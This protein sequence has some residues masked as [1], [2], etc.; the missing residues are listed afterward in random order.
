MATASPSDALELDGVVAPLPG[1]ALLEVT[2]RHRER[3]LAS[4]LTSD[5]A[6][7]AEGEPQLS[8]L[9]DATGR[10]QAL[11]F[12][13]RRAGAFDLLV[14]EPAA[15]HCAERLRSHVI[16]DDV[17]VRQREVG[18]MRLALGPAAVALAAELD[19]AERIPVA[20]W[21]AL[22]LVTW[23]DARFELEAIDD[24]EIEARRVLGGPP[25]W[26][27]E[28]EPGQLVNET[29]LLGS[30]VSFSKGCYR[31]QET[32]AKV[33]SHR[34]A[35]RAPVLLEVPDGLGDGA[36]LV[37]RTFGVGERARAGRALG[38][39]HHDGTSWLQLSLHRELRVAGRQLECAFDGGT[40]VRGTVR[41]LPLL[42][43]PTLEE[44]AERLTTAA[45]AAFA[46]D[47]PDRAL[48]LLD[49]ALAIRPAFADAVEASGVILGRLGRHDE[50]I[51]RMHRLLEVDPTSVMAHSNLSLFYNRL[52]D[53][54]AAERHLA[55]ATRASFGGAAPA[56][57]DEARRQAERAEADRRRRAELFRQVLEVDPD[58]A[59]AH[60]GLGELA[61][62]EGRLGEAADHLERAL[63]AEPGHAAAM[64]ALGAVAE[65][66]GDA[67]R[68]RS[69]YE[70]GVD[71]AAKRGD[72]ATA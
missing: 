39:A 5:V 55:L 62:E 64:L 44:M 42:R 3:F 12:V 13:G 56:L 53:I 14:P 22:G 25:A 54:E 26:S 9:L 71:A 61:A 31:G 21:G 58:D 23:G 52:G 60:F 38:A 34:G 35:V 36:D 46:E 59:L 33:A 1:W 47:R 48:E 4:Q 65:R 66:L 72:F 19:P 8:A 63:A 67:D 29:S 51:A 43:P 16:A 15:A 70:R 37:G 68:A 41:A 24:A 49:R 18:P 57:D 10:V 45:S 2:G 28:V 32:V 11:F 69:V 27:R 40:V 20:G 17:A 30:A 50:A 6:G 7:L